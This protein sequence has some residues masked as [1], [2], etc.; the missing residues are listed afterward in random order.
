MIIQAIDKDQLI[1]ISPET[2]SEQSLT[3][4]NRLTAF[5][6]DQ[7]DI[8]LAFGVASF[9]QD[10]QTYSSTRDQAESNLAQSYSMNFEQ[11]SEQIDQTSN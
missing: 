5:A 10:G 9:P 6:K 3:L 1:V 8:D 4:A 11:V 2:N 7:L